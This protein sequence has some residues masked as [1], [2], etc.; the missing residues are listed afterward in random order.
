MDEKLIETVKKY[1]KLIAIRN[2]EPEGFQYWR[3]NGVIYS[4]STSGVSLN[5]WC[6][7]N[8]LESHL[9][10]LWQV[11]GKKFFTERPD[12]VVIDKQFVSSYRF[13]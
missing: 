13:A 1:G 8:K 3:C 5:F 10:R 4:I 2:G 12:M 11:T 6:S 9:H 7:E